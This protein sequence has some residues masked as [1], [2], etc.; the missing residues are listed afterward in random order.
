MHNV[1]AIEACRDD[2]VFTGC[3]QR[4]RLAR[5]G[6]AR[7]PCIVHRDDAESFVSLPESVEICSR[8]CIRIDEEEPREIGRR[9]PDEAWEAVLRE[10]LTPTDLPAMV[11]DELQASAIQGPGRFQRIRTKCFIAVSTLGTGC[12]LRGSSNDS[13]FEQTVADE[14]DPRKLDL[15]ELTP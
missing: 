9:L 6:Y 5:L 7:A 1:I 4:H 12:T 15:R 13:T 8:H 11:T 3:Q 10:Q 14:V 2:P